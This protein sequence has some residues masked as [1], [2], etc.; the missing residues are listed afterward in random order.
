[1]EDLK[2]NPDRDAECIVVEANVVKGLGTVATTLVKRGTLRVGDIFVAGETHGRA[3]P[4]ISTTDNS[5]MKEAG[6]STPVRVVGFDSVPAAGDLL[7]TAPDEQ[8]ARDL[9]ESRQRIARET[10]SSSYQAG[11]MSSVTTAFEATR[12]TREMCV[13]VKA[14]VQ[15]SAEALTRALRELK[16]E[17]DEVVVNIKVLVSE[18]GEVAKRDIAIAGVT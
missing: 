7:F 12:E 4:L 10:S 15:G 17:N 11:L 14:D 8:T 6:P 5:R 18:S 13:V 3:R 9:A 2:A 16:R 1:V